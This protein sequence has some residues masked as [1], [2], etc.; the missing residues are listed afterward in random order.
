MNFTAGET[1][2][3]HSKTNLKKIGESLS[4]HQFKTKKTL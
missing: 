4:N 2:K 3:E 1:A